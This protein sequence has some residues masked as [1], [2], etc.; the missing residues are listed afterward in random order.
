MA[1]VDYTR[2][3]LNAA[4]RSLGD[5]GPVYMINMVRYRAEA[6]YGGKTELP[7]ARGGKPISSVMPQPSTRLPKVATTRCFGLALYVGCLSR[8]ETRSGMMSSSC[9]IPALRL[10]IAS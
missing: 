5:E 6:D 1:T 2:D 10:C 9:S 3:A 4:N 7:L 8:P